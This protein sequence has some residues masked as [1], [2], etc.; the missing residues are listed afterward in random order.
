MCLQLYTIIYVFFVI[1]ADHGFN[2]KTGGH[3]NIVFS[4]NPLQNKIKVELFTVK[5][6]N[7]VLHKNLFSRSSENII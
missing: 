1:L 7:I 2:L 5:K 6:T 4:Y 3:L